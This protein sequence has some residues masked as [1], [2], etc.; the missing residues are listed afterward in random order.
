MS[1]ISGGSS[2]SVSGPFVQMN[3]MLILSFVDIFE[4]EE[5]NE[6]FNDRDFHRQT[7]LEWIRKYAIPPA[8]RIV[9]RLSAKAQGRKNPVANSTIKSTE[10]VVLNELG[11]GQVAQT[12]R[13]AL[14]V[15]TWSLR[16]NRIRQAFRITFSE[17]QASTGFLNEGSY[18][19]AVLCGKLQK[20]V[21]LPERA[22]TVFEAL[23]W[24]HCIN[25]L[26]TEI[27]NK[28]V[29]VKVGYRVGN[30]VGLI[31][32]R[33]CSA[34]DL[35]MRR[36]VDAPLST[37]LLPYMIYELHNGWYTVLTR[38]Q[39]LS[40]LAQ[41]ESIFPALNPIPPGGEG[42]DPV[43]AGRMVEMDRVFRHFAY[44]FLTKLKDIVCKTALYNLRDEE[45]LQYVQVKALPRPGRRDS[46]P[47][48]FSEIKDE[49]W[50]ILNIQK[51]VP[52]P[53]EV[54]N[55]TDAGVQSVGHITQLSTTL[56][57]PSV[58]YRGPHRPPRVVRKRSMTTSGE[59][60]SK[61]LKTTEGSKA[62][63]NGTS[64][65]DVRVKQEPVEDEVDEMINPDPALS[66]NFD[67]ETK[68]AF[69]TVNEEMQKICYYAAADFNDIVSD[70]QDTTG[71]SLAKDLNLIMTDAPYNRRREQG[72]SNSR[73][74]KL[75]D[76]DMED[77]AGILHTIAAPAAHLLIFS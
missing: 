45:I 53:A 36:I 33:I 77:F 57:D 13:D 6:N 61:V 54:I 67:E 69:D 52:P 25:L 35:L 29:T 71:E 12:F 20:S 75:E 38:E 3:S 5:F 70:Y 24:F 10:D 68:A 34:W 66:K 39:G 28:T 31:V 56:Q 26:H 42:A 32:H 46:L 48:L 27:N 49:I 17:L 1:Q 51:P 4:S 15:H 23:M 63:G 14:A 76:E 50:D 58:V 65:T 2:N 22:P 62:A 43:A 18:I 72:L 41:R 60:P 37:Q 59:R 55:L 47:F 74:D 8:V 21:L 9:T 11:T 44:A 40:P 16:D 7:A 30:V 64:T 73:H 19:Q